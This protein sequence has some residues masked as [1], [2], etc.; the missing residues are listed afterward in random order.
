MSTYISS[1]VIK[2]QHEANNRISFSPTVVLTAFIKLNQNYFEPRS[3][4]AP[5]LSA[6]PNSEILVAASQRQFEGS[7]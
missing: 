1:P 2:L 5:D 7:G 3:R 4:K 6:Q